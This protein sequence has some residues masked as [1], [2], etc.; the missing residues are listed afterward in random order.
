[1]LEAVPRPRPVPRGE[2]REAP[3][4]EPANRDRLVEPGV[5]QRVEEDP[6]HVAPLH[7]DPL[8]IYE[9]VAP[10]RRVVGRG[11]IHGRDDV[12]HVDR[13]GDLVEHPPDEG[14]VRRGRVLGPH[15]H[16]LPAVRGGDRHTPHD[17]HGLQRLEARGP[18]PVG[19]HGRLEDR[20]E[21]SRGLGRRH[22]REGVPP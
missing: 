7:G 19:G 22:D 13:P 11:R 16:R 14:V 3:G 4:D 17:R 8:A 5:E 18:G 6:L 21:R 20:G 1:M 10:H 15:L 9:V 2:R 12:G